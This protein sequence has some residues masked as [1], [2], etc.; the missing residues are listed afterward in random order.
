MG[1]YRTVI[2]SARFEAEADQLLGDKKDDYLEALDWA[3]AL[4]PERGQITDS[5]TIR[6]VT[7]NK[8]DFVFYYSYT[9]DEAKLLSVKKKSN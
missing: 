8:G 1:T 3:I 4:H 5:S 7:S 6:L 9:E 2:H